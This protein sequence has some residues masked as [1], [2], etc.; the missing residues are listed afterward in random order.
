V[1]DPER[2][3]NDHY[4]E[5]YRLALRLLADPEAALDLTQ[6][7][8]YRAV[9]ALPRFRAESSPRTWLYRI[10]VNESRRR[11]VRLPAVDLDAATSLP[12]PAA[13]TDSAAIAALDARRLHALIRTLPQH[14]REAIVLYHLHGLPVTEVAALLGAGENTTKTW[15]HRGRERLRKLWGER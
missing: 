15:L 6:E 4:A 5:V 12:D 1:I 14:E 13:R 8:F 9:R 2:L 7:V 10:T 3:I 11:R